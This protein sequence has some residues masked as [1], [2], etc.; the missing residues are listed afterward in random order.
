MSQLFANGFC[1]R[2][3]PLIETQLPIP[4]DPAAM[5]GDRVLGE[6]GRVYQSLRWPTPS[7]PWR[8]TSEAQVAEGISADA[9]R[10]VP[11]GLVVTVGP[12]GDFAEI[13]DACSDL[14]RYINN[15]PGNI[16]PATIFCQDGYVPEKPLVF[17]GVDMSWQ[18]VTGANEWLM[19]DRA[20]MLEPV[21]FEVADQRAFCAI[22][23]GV[24]PVFDIG[25]EF[26]GNN[27]AGA[28]RIY[29]LHLQNARALTLQNA[30]GRRPV[31]FRKADISYRVANGSSA[32]LSS[33]DV[34]D[35][36]QIG[37]EVAGSGVCILTTG[38][39]RTVHA[40][41]ATA[42]IRASNLG[43]INVTTTG[44]TADF[45]MTEGVDSPND[46]VVVGR[47][48][49]RL[50]ST[51]LGGTNIPLNTYNNTAGSITRGTS[52]GVN[53]VVLS[54]SYGGPGV[55]SSGT[56]NTNGRVLVARPAGGVFGLGNIGNAP[57]LADLDD[58]T[59]ASGFYRIVSVYAGTGPVPP[60]NVG[61]GM[62]IQVERYSSATLFQTAYRPTSTLI[63][64]IWRR[65]FASGSWQPW[66]QIMPSELLGTVSQSGG[67]I[68]GALLQ[69]NAN[70]ESPT[71][72]WTERIADGFQ[73]VHHSLTSSDSADTVWTYNSAFLTGSVPVISIMPVGDNDLRPRLV[74]R[75][76]TT[77]TFSI[78]DSGGARVAVPVDL[79]A[80]G[81]WSNM[82]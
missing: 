41:T 55:Q 11:P 17:T 8:W 47:G 24:A 78:R 70:V 74:A 25:F 65:A 54:E 12:T 73:T 52:P 33:P 79:L 72:G 82:T 30:P 45:R 40:A 49:I 20:A 9:A 44:G 27:P 10:F 71:G 61:H 16:L 81:R 57:T 23:A 39:Y 5:P 7:D 56:D 29:G 43:V 62:L 77:C 60:G 26:F 4:Y 53:P 2:T 15:T 59:L 50:P 36:T 18:R 31:G 66:R 3:G 64:G 76:A 13:V 51:A 21:P 38:N 69:G 46:I 28:T 42:A 14:L 22:E 37:V 67:V 34:Q 63:T 48:T 68:T 6:D 1:N 19:V 32:R 80:R 58:P 35:Y 75:T